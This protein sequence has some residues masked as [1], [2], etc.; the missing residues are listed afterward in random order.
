MKQRFRTE[1][2][3]CSGKDVVWKMELKIGI[4]DS[5]ADWHRKMEE[6]L[7]AGGKDTAWISGEIEHFYDGKELL[8]Y[9][10]A[11][12]EL[13]FI[14]VKLSDGSG[15]AVARKINEIWP[16]CQ[17]I[18]VTE[19]MSGAMEAYE[20][21]HVY[22]ILKEQ[23]AKRIEKIMDKVLDHAIGGRHRKSRKLLL[24]IVRGEQ[25]LLAANEILYF[26]RRKRV[27]IVKTTV[28]TYEVRDKLDIL[29]K[30]LFAEE[31]VRCHT[32]YLVYLPA[33]RAFEGTSFLMRDGS[34]VPISRGYQKRVKHYVNAWLRTHAMTV[35]HAS[36]HFTE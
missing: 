34:W 21:E 23:I 12:L 33:V 32:S 28:G 2:K 6:I 5:D 16:E 13:L 11:P 30:V 22:Y 31:F 9:A 27:T 10:G 35:K 3:G 15:I 24:S 29:E 25:V 26:E 20:T 14:D 17:I 8:L 36:E 4:C 18:F 1:N 7:G 19:D